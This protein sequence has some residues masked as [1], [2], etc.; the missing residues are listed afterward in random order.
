M[1]YLGVIC[2][3]VDA[4]AFKTGHPLKE[5]G[6]YLPIYIWCATV[7]S[8]LGHRYIFGHRDDFVDLPGYETKNEK[9]MAGSLHSA[10]AAGEADL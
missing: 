8:A 7:L 2:C 4:F 10:I 3:A 6:R 1:L 5:I 9:T